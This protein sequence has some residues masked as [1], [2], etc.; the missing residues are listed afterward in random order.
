MPQ[1]QPTTQ[2]PA[3]G[4]PLPETLNPDA[5]D[6]ISELANLISRLR[7]HPAATNATTTPGTQTTPA[8]T[9]LLSATP[10][11]Q[12]QKKTGELTLKE[13]PGA[14]DALRHRFQRARNL[15]KGSLFDLDRTIAEQEI[16]IAALEARIA[17]QRDTLV[18]LRDVGAKLSLLQEDRIEEDDDDDVMET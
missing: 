2:P 5:I 9:P 10:G 11:S 14:T 13:I 8:P 6:V 3:L 18:K 4:L 16:E 15:V 17:R 12:S 1:T 7:T